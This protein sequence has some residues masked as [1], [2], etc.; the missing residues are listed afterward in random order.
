MAEADTERLNALPTFQ[1]NLCP[2]YQSVTLVDETAPV[3]V[4]IEVLLRIKTNPGR[5]RANSPLLTLWLERGRTPTARYDGEAISATA[6][7]ESDP[8]QLRVEDKNNRRTW[9]LAQTPSS[10]EIVVHFQA[11]ARKTDKNTMTSSRID[12]RKDAGGGLVGKG[13]G[14]LPIVPEP[15]IREAGS[16]KGPEQWEVRV[17]WDFSASPKGT[18]GAWSLG[19]ENRSTAKGDLT[20]LISSAIFAVGQMERYPSW[21]PPSTTSPSTVAHDTPP[22]SMYWFGTTV[23]DM[24]VL[25]STASQIFRSVASF[26]SS[27]KPF[28]VFLRKVERG[29]GGSGSTDSFLLEYSDGAAGQMSTQATIELLAHETIHEFAMP[30]AGGLRPGQQAPEAAWYA[31]GIANYYGAL[32]SYRGNAYSRIQL[33]ECLNGFAQSYFTS[34]TV[35]MNYDDVLQSYWDNV[36]ISR[37]SYYRGFMYQAAE[38]GRLIDATG[39]NKSFDDIALGLYCQRTSG[40]PHSLG[41][42][43]SMVAQMLGKDNE[44]SN[45]AAMIRGD[46]IIPHKDCFAEFGL[47][48]IR[49]DTEKFELGFDP[50]SL[51][52]DVVQGL[53]PQSNAASAGL[54]EGDKII[55]SWMAWEAANK[56]TNMMQVTVLRDGVEK[57]VEWWPRSDEKVECWIWIDAKEPKI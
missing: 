43:H 46:L 21:D 57:V 11:P 28:R 17:T 38:N 7:L 14:F 45:Y 23:F 36:H 40:K 35:R 25:P 49:R 56:L 33:L 30:E 18:K 22:F 5:F 54:C 34:P 13:L 50:V 10:E 39:G 8:L 9:Y 47:R 29:H 53:W 19:D 44:A 15:E 20:K 42:Y 31:E 52:E 26:F 16:A 1:L 4:S 55:E 2:Q 27:S 12:L 51:R 24:E 37:V 48:M 41:E 32:L 6:G 3:P